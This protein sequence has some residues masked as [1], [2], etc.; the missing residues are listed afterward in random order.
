MSQRNPLSQLI[1]LRLHK[2]CVPALMLLRWGIKQLCVV[3]V[4][5]GIY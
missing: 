2:A 3:L 5:L 4:L 1:N